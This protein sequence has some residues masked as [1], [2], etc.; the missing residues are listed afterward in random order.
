[1]FLLCETAI[2]HFHSAPRLASRLLRTDRTRRSGRTGQ[3]STV[4]KGRQRIGKEGTAL[5]SAGES[6]STTIMS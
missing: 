1:V 2:C 6:A 4:K 3:R 5:L